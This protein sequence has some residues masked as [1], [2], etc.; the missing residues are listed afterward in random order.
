MQETWINYSPK[1]IYTWLITYTWKDGKHHQSLGM[2]KLKL[3]GDKKKQKP[4]TK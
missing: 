1:K 3:Q 4:R 2:Y